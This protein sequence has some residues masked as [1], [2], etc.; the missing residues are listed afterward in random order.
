PL[1]GTLTSHDLRS[2]PPRALWNPSAFHARS[3]STAVSLPSL[4]LA[5]TNQSVAVGGEMPRRGGVTVSFF[6]YTIAW[7][8]SGLSP[9]FVSVRSNVCCR[10]FQLSL[11]L[12]MAAVTCGGSVRVGCLEA[13]PDDGEVRGSFGFPSW[14]AVGESQPRERAT[15]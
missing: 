12:E 5:S 3:T 8:I 11:T 9:W 10:S 2:R 14:T 13:A 1:A 6:A 4:L 7:I 15:T